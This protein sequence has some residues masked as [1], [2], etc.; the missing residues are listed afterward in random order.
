MNSITTRPNW[1]RQV[2]ELIRIPSG[3]GAGLQGP[4]GSKGRPPGSHVLGGTG[5]FWAVLGGTRLY[6]AVLGSTK[7]Y[8]AV[9]D[10]TRLFWAGLDCTGRY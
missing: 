9:L 1:A 2:H 8:L 3:Q 7:H 10:G 5:L 6:L 4:R